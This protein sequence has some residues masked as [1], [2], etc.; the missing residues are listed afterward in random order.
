MKKI[1]PRHYLI[2]LIFLNALVILF[3]ITMRYR[4]QDTLTIGIFTGSNWDVPGTE[5]YRLFDE[6]IKE[7]QEKYPHMKVN[8]VTGIPVGDYSEWLAG[9]IL[10]GREPDIYFVLPEDLPNLAKTGALENLSAIIY[11]DGSFDSDIFY[12][13]AYKQGEKD[14]IQY[15]LPFE[16]NPRMMFVNKTLLKKE[17]IAMP[18][19]QWKWDDFYEICQKVVKDTNGD[20]TM[21]QYGCTDYTWLDAVY[22][23]GAKPFSEDGK[24]S[25]FNE[26]KV[27]KAVSFVRELHQLHNKN[28]KQSN[29][30]D[31]GKMVFRPL[32]F[33]EYRTYM[34]YPWHIKKYSQF[35]WNCVPMPAGPNG[36][37]VSVME[38][39]M[40]GMNSRTNNRKMV[41]EFMKI[42]T[43]SPSIQTYIYKDTAGASPLRDVTCSKEVI[44]LLNEDTPGDSNINMF[45]LD[46]VM[47]NSVAPEQFAGYE[48]ALQY[49][50]SYIYPRLDNEEELNLAMFQLKNELRKILEK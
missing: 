6:A 16:C 27:V 37:N 12:E 42:L 40:L 22:A 46:D 4:H 24:N 17:N 19:N 45:L 43:T 9:E 38:T 30:F 2:L 25:F 14:G 13:S 32:S 49:A 7:F 11:N 20:G 18:S 8:Y 15:A 26:E 41:W 34:P 50:N 47:E 33:S 10:Q 48:T 31:L 44:E 35:Q 1:K 29:A 28:E 36:Q 5:Y 3:S 23:N 21:D 39:L